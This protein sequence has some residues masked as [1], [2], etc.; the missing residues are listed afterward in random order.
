ML[1]L[2]FGERRTAN[3]G[4]GERDNLIYPG[5]LPHPQAIQVMK[6]VD[7]L[8]M[9]YQLNVSIGLKGHDTARWMSPM[10]MFEYMAAGRAIVSSDLP[11]IREVLNERSAGFCEPGE[12][13]DW[14]LE[15]ESLL[16]SQARRIALGE[17]AR[18]DVQGYTWVARA[19]RIMNGFP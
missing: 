12:V 11:V 6:A 2:L 15:V 9:P 13:G 10:K 16:N 5:F 18:Q 8:L 1:F 19:Q 3:A 14:R 7:V 4:S 17:Q